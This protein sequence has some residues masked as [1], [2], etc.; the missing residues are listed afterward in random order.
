MQKPRAYMQW[1]FLFFIVSGF[2]SVMYELVWLRLSMAQ[3]GVT[4]ALV[5]IVLSAFMAGLGLGSWASG[6]LTRKCASTLRVPALRIYASTELLIGVSALLVPFELH[7]GRI[8]LEHLNTTSSFVYYLASATW[9]ALSLMPWC[10]CMGATI[11]FAMLAIKRTCA[12]DTPRSF[13]FLYLAN[14]LGA[15]A[16]ALLPLLLIE[17]FGFHG[18]LAF[19]AA[20]NLLLAVSAFSLSF[21]G[22]AKEEASLAQQVTPAPLRAYAQNSKPL[23]V[24]FLS[25]LTSMGMEV[26]WIR[27][28]TH[29]SGSCVYTFAGI[30]AT[31]L[32]ATFLG[33]SLYRQWSQKSKP[34][35]DLIWVLLALLALGPLPATSYQIDIDAILRIWLGLIPFNFVLGFVTP[36]LVDRWSGGDPEKA[37]RAY[38]INVLGCIIG[39]LV[40]GFLL[41]PIMSE[42]WAIFTF[43]AVWFLLSICPQW[44]SDSEK[45]RLHLR[46]TQALGALALIA[47]IFTVSRTKDFA[48]SFPQAITLR[49]STATVTAAG[50]GMQRQ[51]LVNGISITTLTPITKMIAHMPLAYLRHRPRNVLVICFGMGTTFRS[52]LSWGIPTTVVELDPS[53]PKLFD[54]FHP[55][56]PELLKSPLAHLVIDDGRRYLE[57]TNEKYDVITLDPPPPIQ[58]PASS[59][60]YSMEFYASVKEHLRPGGIL[61]TWILG[62]DATDHSAITKAIKQSFPFVRAYDSPEHWG[63]HLLA[64]DQPI[65]DFTPQQLVAHMPPAAILDMMEWGPESTPDE[66]FAVQLQ[67]QLPIENLIRQDPHAPP[68]TDDHPVN[69]YYL[70][71]GLF[72]SLAQKLY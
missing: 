10:A 49:D 55:D 35:P 2:C 46:L 45:P 37:G 26:V 34:L 50:S 24:L 64:S 44:L 15:V 27:L 51:L 7:W 19:G 5:S 3:F 13:S 60:L 43:A 4:T 18:T 23:L 53:V 31:Y 36:L 47:A 12:E 28:Y 61:Q 22:F 42:R 52:A 32:L 8:F 21:A 11:P 67:D 72:P 20:C 54:F 58:A 69:E 66:Q 29:Y 9:V 14:V 56:G 38:A 16:G 68:L 17:L 71:R 62:G 59:L 65:P 6:A 40:A 41:L 57:H 48:E 39:P 30:L 70:L 25:G 33:S 63:F 1:I